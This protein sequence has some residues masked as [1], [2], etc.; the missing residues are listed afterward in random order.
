MLHLKKRTVANQ[1]LPILT[2]LFSKKDYPFKNG[3]QVETKGCIVWNDYAINTLQLLLFILQ[4]CPEKSYEQIVSDYFDEAQSNQPKWDNIVAKLSEKAPDVTPV[5]LDELDRWYDE[6]SITHLS[7]QSYH[8]LYRWFGPEV[9]N[10]GYQ[11]FDYFMS[12]RD[13]IKAW[14]QAIEQHLH[15]LVNLPKEQAQALFESHLKHLLKEA[16]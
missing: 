15:N 8:Q 11:A 2:N 7:P 6:V 10:I 9:R 12:E 3:Q 4:I 13:G 16:Q 1:T 14:Q 5:E